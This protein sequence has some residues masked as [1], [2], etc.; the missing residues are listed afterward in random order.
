MVSF[1]FLAIFNPHPQ[2]PYCKILETTI[3][4]LAHNLSRDSSVQIARIRGDLPDLRSWTYQMLETKTYDN[5][6]IC[7]SVRQSQRQRYQDSFITL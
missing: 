1:F 3:E 2:C 4:Q 7:H 5:K 6:T